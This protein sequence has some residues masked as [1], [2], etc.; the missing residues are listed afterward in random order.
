[1]SVPEKT[2]A[3]EIVYSG[4]LKGLAEVDAPDTTKHL[5][6]PFQPSKNNLN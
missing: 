5:F 2:A 1:M 4:T 3:A 6:H